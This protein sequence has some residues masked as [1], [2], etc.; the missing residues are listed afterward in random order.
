MKVII[1]T[2]LCIGCGSC[3]AVF[4]QVFLLNAAEKAEVIEQPTEMTDDL[5][6]AIDSCPV[7]AISVD[8]D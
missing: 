2:D 3:E 8:T 1:D 7:E 4:P 5:Q 6:D